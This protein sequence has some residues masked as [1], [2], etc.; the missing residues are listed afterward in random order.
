MKGT[1]IPPLVT[2]SP[3]DTPRE[4]AGVLGLDTTQILF[5]GRAIDNDAVSGGRLNFGFWLDPCQMVGVE[6]DYLVLGRAVTHFDAASPAQVILA[7]PFLNVET[8]LQDSG[9][10]VYPDVVEGSVSVRGS[11]TFQGFEALLR[12]ALY[13]N[14]SAR[15]DVLIGYRFNRLDD[16]LEI[17]ESTTSLDPQSLVPVGTV[18]AI[19]DVFRTTNQFNGGELGVATSW[20]HCAWSLQSVLKVALGNT[21]SRVNIFGTTTTTLPDG[22]GSAT[23]PGGFLALPT[24]MGTFQKDSFAMIPELGVTL[25]RDL[26]CRLRATV[27]Y[28][29]IYWSKVVRA[30]EQV[31]L[32]LNPTQFPPGTLAGAPEPQFR[33]VTTDFWA[34]GLNFGLDFRF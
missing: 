9:L 2:T 3:E 14:C 17:A 32:N 5:G 21:H 20:R 31:D 12:R 11:S 23:Y 6:A 33:A 15:A 24:N 13:R 10:I 29:L 7:R 18:M 26:T 19:N 27:G 22:G 4:E 16:G 25:G 8:G 30:G 28:S 1:E 34:Q